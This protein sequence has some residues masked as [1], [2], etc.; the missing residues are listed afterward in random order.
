[1]VACTYKI[2]STVLI[3]LLCKCGH[4]GF[5]LL[6]SAL[7]Y[8]SVSVLYMEHCKSIAL[9]NSLISSLMSR[10]QAKFTFILDQKLIT[11]VCWFLSKHNRPPACFLKQVL[12]CKK[13][14]KL[15]SV[16][17]FPNCKFL[18]Y[19]WAIETL[20]NHKEWTII[21]LWNN[22]HLI[23][24]ITFNNTVQY[25]TSSFIIF[26]FACISL[27]WLIHNLYAVDS[28]ENVLRTFFIY[29]RITN[30]EC[31]KILLNPMTLFIQSKKPVEECNK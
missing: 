9:T 5:F 20:T 24:I 25:L 12:I 29:V 11:V 23:L 3:L 30:F 26:F 10:D 16:I 18:L 19:Y 27:L 15:Y 17:E 7:D 4:D 13:R 21:V 22:K 31:F 1:M 14:N 2:F 28:T 6:T 8:I